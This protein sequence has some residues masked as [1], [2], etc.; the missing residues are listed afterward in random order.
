MWI[1]REISSKILKLSK[2]KKVILLTG[3]RQTGKSSLLRKM[4]PKMKYISLDKPSTAHRAEYSGEDFL[5]N[6]PIL[7]L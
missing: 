7:L 5:K 3:P 4:F 6:F 1:N 2:S